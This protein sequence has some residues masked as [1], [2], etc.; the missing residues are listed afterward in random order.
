M[1]NQSVQRGE[2]SLAKLRDLLD[3]RG[4]KRVFL[5]T[6]TRS[7][8]ETGLGERV[9]RF[10]QGLTVER[11]SGFP[12]NPKLE[13]ALDGAARLQAFDPDIVVAIGGG[14]V[15]DTAKLC[16]SLPPDHR[17]ATAIL[18][19]RGSVGASPVPMIAVPTTAGSGSE[20][21]HFAVVY[22][23]GRKYSLAAPQMLPESVIL[24][25]DLT[26][27]ADRYLTIVTAWDALA[28]AI[29]S[30]W[31]RGATEESRAYATNALTACVT[32]IP[33]L[34]VHRDD[35]ARREM[36]YAAHDAGR[37]I[38]ISKTTAAHAM[39]YAFTTH[40]GVAHGHAVALTLGEFFRFH[41]E[42]LH[43]SGD[44]DLAPA[45]GKT[46][47]RLAR[48]FGVSEVSSAA[49]RLCELLQ[50]SGIPLD[51]R[52][53]GIPDRETLVAATR[54]VNTERL[55]NHPV[56]LNQEDL[57]TILNRIWSRQQ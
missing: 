24:D 53:L 29:E 11:F 44:R 15:L 37:A 52:D 33:R 26:R 40:W 45:F 23:G 4:S 12:V 54:E 18:G 21:T 35:E 20:A 46:M 34:Y 16:R 55:H 6:G 51:P 22:S 5:V 19:G 47:E 30:F 56:S 27:T 32:V 7:Y 8:Q 1:W 14:S 17:R 38:N 9:E 48:I 36:M 25:P 43:D 50:S 13:S 41:A 42:L 49:E 31:S 39:S 28:Q 3:E 57:E 2:G 10:L